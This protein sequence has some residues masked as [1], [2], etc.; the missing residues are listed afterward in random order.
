MIIMEESKN[1]VKKV[2]INV[3]R[4]FPERPGEW[5]GHRLVV[6]VCAGGKNKPVKT[7]QT[8]GA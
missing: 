4:Q 3:L 7:V 1:G 2:N 5:A 6:V 8:V